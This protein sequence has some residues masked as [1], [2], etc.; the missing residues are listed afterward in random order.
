MAPSAEER[1]DGIT[2]LLTGEGEPEAFLAYEADAVVLE[3]PEGSPD[4]IDAV[5]NLYLEKGFQLVT[6]PL[7]DQ[8]LPTIEG[9]SL[10]ANHKGVTLWDDLGVIAFTAARGE[11]TGEWIEVVNRLGW[12][13][14]LTGTDLGINRNDFFG[15]IDAAIGAGRV[16]AATV[17]VADDERR[18]PRLGIPS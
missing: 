6:G 8:P 17:R 11:I 9:W 4:P 1:A 10:K 5:V 16:V 13:R 7:A 18:K 2:F 14:V 12:S 3:I 15:T